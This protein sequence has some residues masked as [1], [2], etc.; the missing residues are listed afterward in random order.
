MCVTLQCFS[1]NVIKSNPVT[2]RTSLIG[3]KRL[4]MEQMNFTLIYRER[5]FVLE[6]TIEMLKC[7]REREGNMVH[8]Y[9]CELNGVCECS[10]V[11]L[12]EMVCVRE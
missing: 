7:L 9:M 10:F 2:K 11:C 8:V 3:F 5:E 12:C 4:E 1:A 6:C